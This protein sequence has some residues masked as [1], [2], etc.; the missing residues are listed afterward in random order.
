MEE[1]KKRIKEYLIQINEE[2]KIKD[3]D[4]EELIERVLIYINRKELPKELE[5]ALAKHLIQ[6]EKDELML[7]SSNVGEVASMSDNGQSVTFKS[8]SESKLIKDYDDYLLNGLEPLL[9]KYRTVKVF[10]EDT[11]L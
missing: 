9:D 6:K 8:I 1:S 7:T 11:L 2:N 3:F 4:I 10:R 5:R